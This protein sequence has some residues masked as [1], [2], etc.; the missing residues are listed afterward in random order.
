MIVVVLLLAGSF[1]L[2]SI[3]FGLIVAR[4]KGIDITAVGS[5]NIGATNVAR[6]LGKGPGLLVFG[7][8]VLKGLVPALAARQL[9]PMG[10]AGITVADMATLCGIFAILGHTFSPFMKFKGGKGVATGLG[11]LLGC[12]PDV[13][14]S[15]FGV[16]LV[17]F[18]LTRYVSLA[19]VFAA[20]AMVTFGF[21]FGYSPI[22]LVGYGLIGLFVIVKHI[23]NMKRLA[24]GE[25]PKFSIRKKEPEPETGP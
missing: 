5:G 10:A 23:P 25:E 13:G 14:L 8:D 18:A 6:V 9:V 15:A 22:F 20:V 12:A 17:I 24:K 11:A 7:L 2:G 4:A 1:L 21:V 19:S 3:P 16:F